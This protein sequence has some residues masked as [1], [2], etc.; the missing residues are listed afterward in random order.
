MSL[1]ISSMR[2][3]FGPTVQPEPQKDASPSLCALEQ[4][5]RTELNTFEETRD[6]EHLQT[7][8]D[9]IYDAIRRTHGTLVSVVAFQ[10]GGW[11]RPWERS[12]SFPPATGDK[13]LHDAILHGMLKDIGEALGEWESLPSRDAP[14][15]L[16]HI[17]I[18]RNRRNSPF[19]EF[20]KTPASGQWP[21]D[22]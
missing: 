8:A 10:S 9:A 15:L 3:L 2:K 1:F 14:T 21:H 20:G 5:W 12:F 16:D 19:L 11:P 6:A 7:A 13:S 17:L 18:R 22:D 4:R